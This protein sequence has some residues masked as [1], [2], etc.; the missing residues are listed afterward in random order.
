M[1]AS[2]LGQVRILDITDSLGA[3]A[4]KLLCDLGAQVT[5]LEDEREAILP[6]T[7]SVRQRAADL[8][9]NSGKR[10]VVGDLESEAWDARIESLIET[11]DAVLFSGPFSRF[12]RLRIE[13]RMGSAGSLV[14]GTLTPY[15]LTGPKRRWKGNDLMAWAAGGLAIKMGDP[16]RPPVIPNAGLALVV[17]SQYLA[18]GTLMALRGRSVSGEGQWIDVSLAECVTAMTPECGVAL[19]LD[20]GK[21]KART[22]NHRPISAPYGHYPTLDGQISI[23]AITAAHWISMRQWIFDETGD[24]TV[25]NPAWEGG[26]EMRTGAIGESVDRLTIKLTRDRKKM[27]LFREGQRRGIPCAPVNEV[28]DVL[29]DP[30]LDS[31]G[32]WQ[33]VAHEEQGYRMPGAPYRLGLAP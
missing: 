32:F 28:A 17:G 10:I 4:G 12:E 33:P 14:V 23:I 11:T 21:L 6:E 9:N 15:G 19:F 3:Y 29:M 22:G 13:S 7:Q 31:R 20:D 1:S 24:D 2:Y 16:D 26:P 27:D 8:Y 30:Q 18:I 5:R 25:L